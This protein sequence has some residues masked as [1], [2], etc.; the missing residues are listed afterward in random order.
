MKI[1][2]INEAWDDG[3]RFEAPRS[4]RDELRK[5]LDLR[6]EQGS[7]LGLGAVARARRIAG[8]GFATL[9][10]IARLLEMHKAIDDSDGVLEVDRLIAGGDAGLEW[11]EDCLAKAKVKK[12]P[13][14]KEAAT[15]ADEPGAR[16]ALRKSVSLLLGAHGK[17]GAPV[18]AFK[19]H[20]QRHGHRAVARAL[21]D[22]GAE[23]KDGRVK[24][25][26]P[27]AEKKEERTI[28]KAVALEPLPTLPPAPVPQSVKRPKWRVYRFRGL[29]V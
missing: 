22:I 9:G 24:R 20:V 8:D 23:H 7:A 17:H 14:K 4:V 29:A 15:D 13:A 1:L 21:R 3:E 5:G 10:E 2:S 12:A 25:G 11:A 19:E 27:P 6:A 18:H 16:R 28:E 26:A